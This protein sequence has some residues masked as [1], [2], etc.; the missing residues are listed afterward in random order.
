M[1]T[2]RTGRKISATKNYRLFGGSDEN[3]PLDLRKH[4]K[5]MDSMK[6]Y[7]FLESYPIV[8]HRN[9]DKHLI[10][11]DGQHRLAVAEALGLPVYWVEE[12]VDF[13]VAKINCT[14]K[15]WTLRD[16]AQKHAKN[17]KAA[18]QEGLEF[19]EQHRLPIGTA[20]SLLAGTTTFSNVQNSFYDGSFSIRDRQWADA[21]A[22]IYGPLVEMSVD[23]RNARFVEACMAV[24]RVKEFDAK[25]LLQNA[26]RCRE[27]LVSFSTRDAYLDMLEAIY[28][29]G[30]KTL[31][32]LKAEATMVMRE[33]NAV[34][35]AKKAKVAKKK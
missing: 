20:F 15:T 7:G 33:R 9:G 10:V 3:R 1:A 24:C 30:R 35:A 6:E 25:R 32:G 21:V 19:V 31:V 34:F 5:L 17:G 26:K 8:C 23:I 28:N 12:A 22:G 13:D 16:F 18:Y 14:P 29:Y 11:K 4:K 2:A 27:K